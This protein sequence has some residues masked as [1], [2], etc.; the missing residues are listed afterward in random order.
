MSIYYIMFGAEL[1]SSRHGSSDAE[2]K[3]IVTINYIHSIHI[4]PSQSAFVTK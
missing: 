2:I 1:L 4:K 3:N